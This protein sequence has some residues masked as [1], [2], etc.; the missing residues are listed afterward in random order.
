MLA[1]ER[2]AKVHCVILGVCGCLVSFRVTVVEH[3]VQALSTNLV[4]RLFLSLIPLNTG[5]IKRTLFMIGFRERIWFLK[6]HP[7]SVR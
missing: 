4:S 7:T 1:P 5:S 3:L 2:G 6:T